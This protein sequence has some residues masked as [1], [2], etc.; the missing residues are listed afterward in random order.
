M[1]LETQLLEPMLANSKDH[2]SKDR[3]HR[4]LAK[5]SELLEITRKISQSRKVAETK[6]V[7]TKGS[8]SSIITTTHR[9]Q[10][11]IITTT[12]A[13]SLHQVD[14]VLALAQHWV[15]KLIRQLWLSD[16]RLRLQDKDLEQDLEQVSGHKPLG[17]KQQVLDSKPLLGDRQVSFHVED[18]HQVKHHRLITRCSN[19][20]H[21]S[22]TSSHLEK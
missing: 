16:R 4:H 19:I 15:N 7:E 3:Q 20:K 18:L 1:E 9:S 17:H 2:P 5:D 11:E 13:T 22:L 12:A 14:L 6:I 8:N 21:H 10:K